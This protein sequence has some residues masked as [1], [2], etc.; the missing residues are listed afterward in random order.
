MIEI[1]LT[2]E[3]RNTVVA[4][5]DELVSDLR[6][7]IAGTDSLDYRDSLKIRKNALMKLTDALRAG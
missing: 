6:M 2:E 1:D 3:E 4:A 5:L 7:E